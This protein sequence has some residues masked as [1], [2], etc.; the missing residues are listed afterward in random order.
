MIRFYGGIVLSQLSDTNVE[1]FRLIACPT[2]S[3]ENRIDTYRE[4]GAVLHD[5]LQAIGWG[6]RIDNLRVFIDGQLIPDAEWAHVVPA[7]GQA[8]VVRRILQ[9]SGGGQGGSQGKQIG[10]IIAMVVLIAATW[11]VGG[12]GLAGLLPE[13]LQMGLA[14]AWEGIGAAMLIGG[15]LAMNALIS[16]NRPRLGSLSNFGDGSAS[17]SLTGAANEMRPYARIPRLYGTHRMYPLI[18][19]RPFTEIVGSNQYIRILYCFGYG[20]LSFDESTFK[21][22]ETPL[23]S[24]KDYEI[25]VRRGYLNDP[26]ITLIPDDIYEDNESVQLKKVNSWT[27]RTSQTNAKELSV[28]IIFPEGLQKFN[29][30]GRGSNHTVEVDIQYR[31]VGDVSWVTVGGSAAVSANETTSFPNANSNLKFT[32]AVSGTAGNNRTIT[33]IVGAAL[34]IAFEVYSN[35]PQSGTTQTQNILISIVQG[36]TTAN[37]VKTA[38]N[39]NAAFVA[40]ATIADAPGNNGTGAIELPKVIISGSNN[41]P[42]GPLTLREQLQPLLLRNGLDHIPVLVVTGNERSL[43]RRNVRWTVYEQGAQYEIRIRRVTSDAPPASFTAVDA[44]FWSVTRT[45]QSSAAFLK[46]GLAFVALR[47]KATGQL[48]GTVDTFNGVV[49]SILR[50]WD[51]TSGTWIMRPTNNPASVYRDVLQGTANRRPKADSQLDLTTIQAFHGR[52]ITNGYTFNAVIDFQTTVKQ[53][54]QD[55]L[56]AARAT[57]GLK[58]MKYSVIED[59]AQSTPVDVITPRTTS[60]FKWTRR[61]LRLPHAFKVRFI[62]AD[63]GYKQNENYVYANGYNANNATDFEETDAGIGVTNWP[64]VWSLKRKELADVTLRSDDYEVTIDFANLNVTRGDRVQLQ[65]DV[66]LA[67]LCTARI[68]SVTVDGSSQATDITFD[69]PF[70]MV[71][72]TNYGARIRKSNGTQVV[73]QVVTAPGEVLAVTFSAPLAV[74]NTPAVGDLVSFGTLGLETIDCIVKSVNPGADYTATLVLQDY[75][76]GIQTAPTDATITPYA[77]QITLPSVPVPPIPTIVQVLSDES[78]LVRDIDGSFAPRIVISL[79]FSS[80]IRL[81]T[82]KIETQFRLTG[83]DEEW[84]TIYTVF[85]GTSVEVS[86]ESVEEG[87]QYDIQLRAIDEQSGLP[88]S[89]A[90]IDGHTVLGKTSAPAD[91]DVCVLEDDRLR[92]TYPN[93][94]VDLDGFLVRYRSGTSRLWDS[95]IEAHT[96]VIKTTDFQIFRQPGIWTFMVKAIDTSGNVSANPVG[97]TINLG[98]ILVDNV[99]ITVD[100]RALVWP[101]TRTNATVSG[102]DLAANSA[103]TFW[104]SDS[105]PAYPELDTDLFWDNPALEMMY[106]FS[107]APPFDLLDASIKIDVT[108]LGDWRLEYRT[109]STALAWDG[110]GGTL[111]WGG[112]SDPAWDAKGNYIA[113]PGEISSLLYQQY[114]FRFVGNA[115]T[116]QAVL[117]Q[118]SLILDV[119]DVVEDVLDFTIVSGGTR[120]PLTKTFRTITAVRMDLQDDGGTATNLK[121]VDKDYTLGPL[122]IAYDS[123]LTTTSAVGDFRI[124]GY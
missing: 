61:F 100:H 22:G 3:H 105:T 101:G 86:I 77:S 81:V 87:L 41:S 54:R 17:L 99:I 66:I 102:G 74:G 23:S 116:T 32:R 15:T 64:Q 14:G 29:Q 65:H 6:P 95:A 56:A 67:G 89:W 50:D 111:M 7:A 51:A 79:H 28:D 35:S 110:D 24:F 18:A 44:T 113:W 42:L 120:L 10:M 43:I 118:L 31:K 91:I 19:A 4:P 25:Q 115:G 109:D 124:Q 45:I 60:G 114:D 68:K 70:T 97:V 85:S 16:P 93:P 37:Q 69:E 94:P 80:G 122:V 58:D 13:A 2:L 49:T 104:T 62:D 88:G 103:S 20:P 48:N 9:D 76:P 39:A 96:H 121:L 46:A 1:T 8:V 26:P 92:W 106:E 30:F 123:T 78:V 27:V 52:N 33:F 21:I 5:H 53:L 57:F 90:T 83:S 11:Y 34:D 73:S 117:Q 59:L 71:S 12:G 82:A 75:A 98:D 40:V 63:N 38:W 119:I 108:A 84:K 55:V 107:Y 72:G 112:S 47:I 36:V